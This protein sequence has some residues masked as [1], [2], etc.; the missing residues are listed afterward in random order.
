MSRSAGVFALAL[1]AA[2][3]GVPVVSA[4]AP[5]PGLTLLSIPSAN[6]GTCGRFPGDS[7]SAQSAR[8]R[9]SLSFEIQSAL[10]ASRTIAIRP[11]SGRPF[12]TYTELVNYTDESGNVILRSVGATVAPDGQVAGVMDDRS[13]AKGRGRSKTPPVPL[14]SIQQRQVR[15]LVA[16]LQKRCGK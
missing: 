11:D 6:R 1:S 14:D 4:Q 16:W 5:G 12:L 9:S 10:G 2:A 15:A 8:T 13:S 7:G 3:L